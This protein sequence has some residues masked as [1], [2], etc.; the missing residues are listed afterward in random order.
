MAI[1]DSD[2][3]G[4]YNTEVRI[5]WYKNLEVM[6]ENDTWF[7]EKPLRGSGERLSDYRDI[8][9]RDVRL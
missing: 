9:H 4:S 8:N 7:E 1:R 6:Y 5:E 3:S 2:N